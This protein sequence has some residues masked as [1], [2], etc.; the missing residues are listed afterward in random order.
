MQGKVENKKYF[1]VMTCRWVNKQKECMAFPLK[2]QV[3]ILESVRGLWEGKSPPP[4]QGPLWISSF[5][6]MNS[7]MNSSYK[8]IRLMNQYQISSPCSKYQKFTRLNKIKKANNQSFLFAFM[9]LKNN[10][11][12]KIQNNIPHIYIC[13]TKVRR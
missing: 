2:I 1:F 8:N 10:I 13:I 5:R 3:N 6:L 4:I 11:L 12:Q 9:R 7:I